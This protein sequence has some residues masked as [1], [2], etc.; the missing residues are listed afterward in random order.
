MTP[1]MKRAWA[2]ALMPFL[3]HTSSQSMTALLPKVEV[4]NTHP[5][6]QGTAAWAA[7]NMRHCSGLSASSSQGRACRRSSPAA[8]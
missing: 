8:R 3:S 4:S 7:S 6:V 1:A 5:W 2:V